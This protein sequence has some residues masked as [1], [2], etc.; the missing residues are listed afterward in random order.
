M[1]AD[2]T[3]TLQTESL[4]KSPHEAGVAAR[5]IKGKETAC[6]PT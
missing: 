3:I 2:F 5:D 4:V 1:T 6:E